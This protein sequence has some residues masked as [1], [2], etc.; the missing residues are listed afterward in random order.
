MANYR[1]FKIFL[2]G[3]QENLE[4]FQ[5]SMSKTL[6]YSEVIAA[7][8]DLKLHPEKVTSV[9]IQVF[10][11]LGTYYEPDEEDTEAGLP[12]GLICQEATL[13]IAVD[14]HQEYEYCIKKGFFGE[15]EFPEGYLSEHKV[16]EIKDGRAK[17]RALAFKLG[18]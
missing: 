16:G 10:R 15:F 7:L 5:T 9:G 4:N 14:P 1:A 6:A 11:P 18:N 17:I 3:F 12:G 2:D 8:D 13:T